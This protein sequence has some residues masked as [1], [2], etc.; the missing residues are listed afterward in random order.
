M[1]LETPGKDLKYSPFGQQILSQV[2][3]AGRARTLP[4]LSLF[5]AE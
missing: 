2:L 3:D 5:V 1:A 4:P